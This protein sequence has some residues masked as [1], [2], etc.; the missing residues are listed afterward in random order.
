MFERGGLYVW[1]TIK[2][3]RKRKRWIL[4]YLWGSLGWITFHVLK[5]CV[6]VCVLFLV[7]RYEDINGY[8]GVTGVGRE[9]PGPE[10][11]GGYK[12]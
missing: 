1:A 5:R 3:S 2:H 9:R 12:N 6:F 4:D 7:L 10:L 11:L 8:V